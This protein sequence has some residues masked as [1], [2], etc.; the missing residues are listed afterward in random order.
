MNRTKITEQLRAAHGWEAKNR[1]LIQLARDL[2]PFPDNERTD[3]NR[4]AGC[5]SRVWL[6]LN[7][8]EDRLT[9]ATDSDSRIVKGLLVLVMAAY[10]QR[11]TE[12]ITTFDFED[13]LHALGLSRFLSSS[14]GT[15]LR[16]IVQEIRTAANQNPMLDTE[17]HHDSRP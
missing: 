6:T 8:D 5:E 10:Q 17:R 4:V 13:W 1:L 3:G 14:R 2:P 16:A 9:I 12:E 15:G 7:W 11:S